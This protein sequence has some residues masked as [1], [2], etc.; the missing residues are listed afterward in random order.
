MRLHFSTLAILLGGL[1]C[2]GET[3]GTLDTST[4]STTD[5][6][7][8]T[9]G[10]EGDDTW[11]ECDGDC[12]DGYSC[13]D[14]QCVP[15]EVWPCECEGDEV[16]IDEVCV[17]TNAIPNCAPISVVSDETMVFL[18]ED[19][20]VAIG[21][22]DDNPGLDLVGVSLSRS[23]TWHDGVLVESA[24][25]FPGGSSI[26][27]AALHINADEDLDIAVTI[28]SVHVQYQ[29]AGDGVGG[30]VIDKQRNFGGSPPWNVARVRTAPG[31]DGL[32]V[33][34]AAEAG[35][36]EG[37][38]YDASTSVTPDQVWDGHFDRWVGD[39]DGDAVDE[40]VIASNDKAA[41]W[42][43][44]G[45][46]YV[47]VASLDV[48]L[49]P[50]PSSD[51]C[52]GF[53]IGDLDADGDEDIVCVAAG[54]GNIE[55]WAVLVPF[56]NVGDLS[57]ER[58]EPTVIASTS[59]TLQVFDLDGDASLE[60]LLSDVVVDLGPGGSF[61]CASPHELG[62]GKTGDL[63]GDGTDELVTVDTDG[64]VQIHDLSW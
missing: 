28:P 52:D 58:G 34:V 57:W 3:P 59:Q 47:E 31:V 40:L 9:G 61:E 30:F 43:H 36:Y 49:D 7:T 32:I 42:A 12:P 1:A 26:Q 60:L 25:A 19:V 15:P 62:R 11:S 46:A 38:F 8:D 64:T 22:F 27:A 4:T 23:K 53:A 45:S 44:S 18:G 33:E 16:C 10:N 39:F 63:D 14:D 17:P 5:T 20:D 6:T 2:V 51:T 13:V 41:I 24:L 35:N 55:G 54:Y 29:L 37:L 21:E 50:L 56:F 48:G